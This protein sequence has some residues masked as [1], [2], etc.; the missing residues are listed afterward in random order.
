M[1]SC[2]RHLVRFTRFGALLAQELGQMNT[3]TCSTRPGALEHALGAPP[4]RAAPRR[5]NPTPAPVA[6]KATPASTVH[7]RASLTQPELKF[8]GVCLENGVLAAVQATTTVYRPNQPLPVP[9]DPQ[10]SFYGPQ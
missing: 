6:I 1:R 2:T 4:T 9:S 7:P 10:V 3:T 5:A 8:A